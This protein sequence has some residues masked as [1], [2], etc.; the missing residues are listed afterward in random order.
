[1]LRREPDPSIL[2]IPYVFVSRLPFV[3]I[4]WSKIVDEG[5]EKL[6]LISAFVEYLK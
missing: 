1:M 2:I 4:L 3:S 6:F 5:S